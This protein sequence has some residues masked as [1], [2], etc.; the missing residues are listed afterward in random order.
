[1]KIKLNKNLLDDIYKSLLYSKFDYNIVYGGAGSGKS[2]ALG[3]Y[4]TMWAL[5]GR[6]ILSTISYATRIKDST[7][8]EVTSAIHEFKLEKYFEIK[9]SERKIIS[10]VSNGSIKFLGLDDVTKLRSI[11]PDKKKAFDDIVCEEATDLTEDTYNLLLTRQRGKSKFNKRVWLAFNPVYINHWIY[12]RFFKPYENDYD[13]TKTQFKLDLG[14]TQIVKTTY[15]NNPGMDEQSIKR[16]RDA[17]G[18]NPYYADVYL[19][20]NFGVLGETV[21]DNYTVVNIDQVKEKLKAS[22]WKPM[23]GID[24]GFN[25]AQTFS[26]SFYNKNTNESIIV[27]EVSLTKVS[28][29]TNYANLILDILDEWSLSRRSLITMDS[30]DTRMKELLRKAGLNVK[31]AKKGPGS[32]FAGLMFLKSKRIYVLDS[33]KLTIDSFRVYVWKKDKQGNA[34]DD[35]DH[36]GSDLLDAYRYAHEDEMRSSGSRLGS[37]KVTNRRVSIR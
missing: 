35:T 27:G 3:V 10:K 11:R 25:D 18:N 1:M 2:V 14:D 5:Q 15:R 17:G 8:T 16:L 23:L 33:C 37:D 29:P 31:G 6:A 12:K 20:G 13:Y 9:A 26:L 32:K 36:N 28:D 24:N 30:N 21:Y 7:W 19:D 4:M 22:K 34:L